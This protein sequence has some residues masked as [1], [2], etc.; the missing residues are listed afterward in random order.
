MMGSQ[1]QTQNN[2]LQ[3]KNSFNTTKNST[4]NL[5]NTTSPLKASAKSYSYGSEHLHR[6]QIFYCSSINRL[7]GLFAKSNA[8]DT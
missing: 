3:F 6:M 8:F 7:P 5:N 2:N 1:P 4:L